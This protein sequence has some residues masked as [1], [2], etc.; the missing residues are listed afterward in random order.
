MRIEAHCAH[1]R[2]EPGR[3]SARLRG[4]LGQNHI[5]SCLLHSVDTTTSVVVFEADAK[6]CRLAGW[7]P[8]NNASFCWLQE[9]SKTKSSTA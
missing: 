3:Y 9:V 8:T 5:L 4:V 6:V 2:E 1:I 7:T